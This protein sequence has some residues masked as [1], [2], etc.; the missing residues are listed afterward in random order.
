MTTIT[1]NATASFF[2]DSQPGLALTLNPLNTNARLRH[3]VNALLRSDLQKEDLDQ[4]E[5]DAKTLIYQSPRDARGYSALGE[6]LSRLERQDEADKQFLQ[7]LELAPTEI[8]ALLNRLQRALQTGRFDEAVQRVDL[9]LRRWPE[10]LERIEP[11]LT[12]LAANR[13]GA[14]LLRQKLS[15]APPW[16]RN[17]IRQLLRSETGLNF[18]K[19]LLV[20]DR[21]NE[22]LIDQAEIAWTLI[23]LVGRREYF[24]AYRTF[25]LTLSKDEREDLGYVYNGNFRLKPDFRIF[26]WRVIQKSGADVAV[27]HHPAGSNEGGTLSV[28]FRGVPAKLGNVYQ[29]LLLPSGKYTLF[30]SAAG[31]ALVIPKG[32]FWEIQCHETKRTLV[33]LP[34]ESGTYSDQI[35]AQDF[36]VPSSHCVMQS[37]RLVTG[38]AT[39]T[40]RARYRGSL[41]VKNLNVVKSN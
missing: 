26:N 8:N 41:A 1:L 39:A 18:T 11:V 32:L 38:V 25:L 17:F 15:D 24:E 31:R 23:A 7:A 40:W 20:E 16:R 21:A 30:V 3:I 34:L 29:S 36:L 2:E 28:Q 12:A 37:L 9:I 27:R 14:V 22:R 6:V 33:R 13:A 35:F 4:L 19:K 10:Y 5:L